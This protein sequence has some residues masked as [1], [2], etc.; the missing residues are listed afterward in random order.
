MN[1]WISKDYF[2]SQRET[3]LKILKNETVFSFFFFIFSDKNILQGYVYKV[4]RDR[5][6]TRLKIRAQKK[7]R[8][9]KLITR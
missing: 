8:E 4:S 9:C 5:K 2:L 1:I 3:E 7:R 6:G